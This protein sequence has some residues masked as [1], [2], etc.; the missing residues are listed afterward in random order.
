MGALDGA[1][2]GAG[3]ATVAIVIADAGHTYLIICATVLLA[4]LAF[5]WLLQ[6][7]AHRAVPVGPPSSLFRGL[8]HNDC[9][10]MLIAAYYSL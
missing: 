3:V 6:P 5:K 9:A 1:M 4:L 10:R 7:H 8:F 2:I